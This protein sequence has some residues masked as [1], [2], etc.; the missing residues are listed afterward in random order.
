MMIV[1]FILIA[2]LYLVIGFVVAVLATKFI[3]DDNP[4]LSIT[5][6][7]NFVIV[8]LLWEGYLVI[9]LISLIGDFIVKL[10]SKLDKLVNKIR[11]DD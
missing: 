4:L 8:V 2:V 11:E 5:D 3:G 7:I 9:V 6:G 1:Y 10:G